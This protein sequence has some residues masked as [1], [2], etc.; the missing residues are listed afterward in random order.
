MWPFK[1]I[2]IWGLILV[3]LSSLADATIVGFEDTLNYENK[4]RLDRFMAEHKKQ[5]YNKCYYHQAE[6]TVVCENKNHERVY[7]K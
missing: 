1:S 4:Y 5:G 2:I 7:F 6:D 3:T